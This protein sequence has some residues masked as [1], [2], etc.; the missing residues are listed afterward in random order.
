MVCNSYLRGL[1]AVEQ[2]ARVGWSRLSA[3]RSARS[4]ALV[5]LMARE[6]YVWGVMV[7]AD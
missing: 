3:S 4:P 6:D 7:G 5:V 1:V 2:M